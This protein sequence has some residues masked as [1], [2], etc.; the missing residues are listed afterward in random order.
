MTPAKLQ[1]GTAA[2]FE[3]VGRLIYEAASHANLPRDLNWS[4][5][6]RYID[7]VALPNG[8]VQGLRFEI[9]NGRPSF[10]IGVGKDERGDVTIEIRASAARELNLLYASD[11]AYSDARDRLIRQG[12]MRV[13]GDL[14]PVADWLGTV[15]NPIVD[16]TC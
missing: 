5:V 1:H 11:P 12:E 9:Q 16:R 2:W 13:Y 6:E 7:G 8:R 14:S 3:M 10:Q 15:H 4:L